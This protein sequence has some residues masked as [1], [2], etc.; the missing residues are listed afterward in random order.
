MNILRKKIKAQEEIF[1]LNTKISD[2]YFCSKKKS[3]KAQ[4]EMVG[5]ALI[6][7]LVAIIFLVFLAVYVKKPQSE[8]ID[9]PEAN[10]FV[11][12]FLQY[13]TTCEQDSEN[14]TVQRLIIKCQEKE[15][16]D[17]GK[18]ICKVLN[19]TIK[20]IIKESWNVS[21]QNPVKGYS[22]II[23]TESKQVLN[24]TEGVVTNNYK[25]GHQPLPDEELINVL[26]TAYN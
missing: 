25:T 7:I 12:S 26:F 1:N 22:L 6:I 5:F 9:N 10:S 20:N 21:S 4:E 23:F 16:C 18:E 13:T 15:K 2:L 11:Q 17:S 14:I 19:D 8:N 24:I 3:T